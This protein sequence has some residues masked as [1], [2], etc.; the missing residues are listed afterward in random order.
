MIQKMRIVG[1]V[2]ARRAEAVMQR[3]KTSYQ[4]KFL[5][6]SSSRHP[7]WTSSRAPQVSQCSGTSGLGIQVHSSVFVR[8]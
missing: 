5:S 1:E 6:T 7:K 2:E 3:M 8:S 4:S